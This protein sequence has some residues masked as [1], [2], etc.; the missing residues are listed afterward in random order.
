MVIKSDGKEKYTIIK[1]QLEL[2]EENI[3]KYWKS[4]SDFES[5]DHSAIIAIRVSLRT[6]NNCNRDWAALVRWRRWN[7]L[8]QAP[9]QAF[10]SLLYNRSQITGGLFAKLYSQE[11]RK[12]ILRT[13]YDFY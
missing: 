10:P 12:S 7:G 9:F 1:K 6:S 4:S 3:W 13:T 11:M 5:F 2:L 8:Q